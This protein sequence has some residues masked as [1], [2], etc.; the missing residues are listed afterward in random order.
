[1]AAAVRRADADVVHAHNYHAFPLFFAALGVTDTR[2][3]VTTH[4]HGE[5]ASRFRDVLL[6]LY[7]P[8]GRWAVGQADE[9]IAVSEWD[10]DRLYEDF[11]VGATVIPNGVD[12]ERFANTEHEKRER[13]YL[14][15]VGRL[16]EYKGI[17]HA[18]RALPEL[19]EYELVVA[20]SG[21]YREELE[22]IAREE[23]VY[24]RMAFL[25][26]VDSS[27]LPPLYAGAD[28]YIALSEFESYGMTV[29]ESLAART[30]C[31]IRDTGGLSD[32][33]AETG[34]RCLTDISPSTVAENVVEAVDDAADVNLATWDDVASRVSNVYRS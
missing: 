14:L 4:Y 32:W 23:D 26:F 2:F 33:C 9:V 18:I 30:P 8:I 22:R 17:Q 25:G 27:R 3:V 16:E 7:R 29:A 19:P 6:S 11:D 28:V 12:V 13:P 1:M 20:G 10:R 21:P 34:V 15:C 31:V 24:D 5:S